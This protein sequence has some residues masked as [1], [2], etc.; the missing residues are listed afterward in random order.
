MVRKATLKS[1]E[2]ES[3]HSERVRVVNNSLK[4]RLDDLKTF[5]PLTERSLCQMPIRLAGG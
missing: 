1:V 4:L 5:D 2:A 3:V